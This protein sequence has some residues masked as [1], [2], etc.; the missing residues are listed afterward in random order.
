M[1][2]PP[3]GPDRPALRLLAEWHEAGRDWQR[4]IA[5]CRARLVVVVD[6]LDGHA[7]AERLREAV[8]ALNSMH[9]SARRFCDVIE[10]TRDDARK[11]DAERDA[12][13]SPSSPR[14]P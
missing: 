6:A 3:D 14:E 1:V 13:P 5:E 9:R 12:S 7:P 8:A 11:R 2:T 4:D 10:A